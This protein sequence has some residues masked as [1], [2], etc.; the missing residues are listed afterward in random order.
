MF[1]AGISKSQCK[2]PL[3]NCLENQDTFIKRITSCKELITN[4]SGSV[5]A[6]CVTG[7]GTYIMK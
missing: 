6:Y 3:R 2:F 5:N 1:F 7:L 4:V